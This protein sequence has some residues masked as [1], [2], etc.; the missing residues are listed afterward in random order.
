M[1]ERKFLY[2]CHCGNLAGMIHDAGAVVSC[3]GEP[4]QE[5]R[6]ID[7]GD[8]C[9]IHAEDQTTVIDTNFPGGEIPQWVYLQ[10]NVGGQRKKTEGFPKVSFHLSDHERAKVAYCYFANQNIGKLEC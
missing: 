2:C 6:L 3:C 5:P 1:Q 7:I 8:N 9:R 10:T 4:M